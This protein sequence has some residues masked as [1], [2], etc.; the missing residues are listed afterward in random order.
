LGIVECGRNIYTADGFLGLFR[1]W[2]ASIIGI[3]PFIGIKMMSFDLL[4]DR[5]LPPSRD[6]PRF[7]VMNLVLGGVTGTIAVTLTYPSD[8]VR[9]LIQLS[10]KDGNPAYTGIIDCFVKVYQKEGFPGWFRGLVP[11]YLKVIPMMAILFMCNERLKKWFG[12]F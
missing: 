6:D 2:A 7:D 10:G 4:K 9:R 1:G 11:C 3:T 5:F 12:M 8:V